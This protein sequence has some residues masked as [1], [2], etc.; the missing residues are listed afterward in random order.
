MMN[1]SSICLVLMLVTCNYLCQYAGTSGP[2]HANIISE[3]EQKGRR[4]PELAV[5]HRALLQQG[6]HSSTPSASPKASHTSHKA[7]FPISS[8][9]IAILVLAGVVLFI[10]AGEGLSTCMLP[11]SHSLSPQVGYLI[12]D[13]DLLMG[14]W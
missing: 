1:S 6:S 11:F 9:D 13:Y 14:R 3:A 7:L 5:A 12:G 4:V 2:Q 8:L 10:A